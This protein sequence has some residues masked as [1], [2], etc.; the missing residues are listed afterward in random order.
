MKP[1]NDSAA[2]MPSRIRGG[3]HGQDRTAE[4]TR[5]E[6]ARDEAEAARRVRELFGQIA[7][8]YDFLNHLLSFSCDRWWRRQTARRVRGAFRDGARV[9]DVCCGTG[10]LAFA[11]ERAARGLAMNG[12]EIHAADFAHPMLIRARRK[13]ARRASRVRFLAADALRLPFA[14]ATFD[15]GSV[16]FG[17]RNLAS[18]AG[19]IDEFRRVLRPGGTLAILEFSEPPGPIFGPLYRFYFRN[20]LPAIGGLVSGSRQ[21]YG[22]LPASVACF[23]SPENLAA[24]LRAAGFTRVRF[25]RWTGGIV[26]LHLAER[27]AE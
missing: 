6:G 7:G 12:V 1:P 3:S 20:L 24:Q 4:G 18:Y 26:A 23:P 8:R 15:L 10:D 14:D 27:P 25:E 5:P 13:A 11:F 9:L 16:A 2:P 22:Y 19:G 17:F 21:A